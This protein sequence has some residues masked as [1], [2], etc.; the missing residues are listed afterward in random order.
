M[1]LS[2]IVP[3][4]N[5]E[6]YV[7][8]C[9][10]SLLHPVATD[11]EIVVVND[12]TLDKSIDLI[13]EKINDMRVRILDKDNGGLSS[14]RN[15]GARAALGDYLWF[16][17]SDDWAETN[18]IPEVLSVLN[19]ID[20][21]AFNSYYDYN[22]ANGIKNECSINRNCTTGRE[23]ARSN[24]WHCVPFY[25]YSRKLWERENLSF[26]EGILHE[27]S[28]F[29]PIT[30]MKSEIVRCYNRS[31]YNRRVRSGSITTST[32]TPKRLRDLQYVLDE[33]VLFGE[34]LDD[35][36]KYEWGNCIADLVN[37]LLFCS[38]KCKDVKAGR[39]VAQFVNGDDR[40]IQYLS[41]SGLN[42]KIIVILA[43][44]LFGDL[45]KAYSMLYKIR[46]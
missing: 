43:K 1:K 17:D 9:I 26:K 3:V 11:Y 36:I 41:H 37:E 6:K 15:Y 22:D 2:I 28:L 13:R 33:L 30:I 8:Q 32:V 35:D 29:T 42:N 19:E 40:F 18:C 34:N 39:D 12:G 16:F 23:L 45:Y 10:N 25:I 14:A 44:L 24:F 21:L 4:Y 46:Y 20:I 7:V 27:D 31:V 5:V 38:Q